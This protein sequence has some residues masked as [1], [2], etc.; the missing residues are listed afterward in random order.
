[1]PDEILADH[2]LALTYL[3]VVYEI[4]GASFLSISLLLFVGVRAL[5]PGSYVRDSYNSDC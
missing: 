4:P 3:C 5:V 1:M 2:P